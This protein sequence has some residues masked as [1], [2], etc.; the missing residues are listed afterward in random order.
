MWVY[1]FLFRVLTSV[2]AIMS[3][4]FL[5]LGMILFV[6]YATGSTLSSCLVTDLRSET[7][8]TIVIAWGVLLESREDLASDHASTG[9]ST[10]VV[11]QLVTKESKRSGLLLVCLGLLLEILSYFDASIHLNPSPAWMTSVLHAIVWI[12]L[13]LVC[14]ELLTSWATLARIHLK[15]DRH[16]DEAP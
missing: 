6:L 2:P 8:S 10:G 13:V 9:R 7:I 16:A 11:E 5:I 14:I 4:D 12:V 3:G 1:R 15:G